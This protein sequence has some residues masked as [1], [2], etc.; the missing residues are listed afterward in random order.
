MCF[1]LGTFIFGKSILK[2]SAV[3]E[4]GKCGV[5]LSVILEL[6]YLSYPFHQLWS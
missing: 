3:A 2:Q 5:W 6:L 4:S 1:V